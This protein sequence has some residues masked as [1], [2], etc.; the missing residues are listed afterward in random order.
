VD[1]VLPEVQRAL[2]GVDQSGGR[3]PPPIPQP[4]ASGPPSGRLACQAQY[5]KACDCQSR[6]FSLRG[7]TTCHPSQTFDW[8][9]SLAARDHEDTPSTRR[10]SQPATEVSTELLGGNGSKD[11]EIGG[12]FPFGL[13]CPVGVRSSRIPLARWPEEGLCKQ[14][15][16]E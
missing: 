11:E 5:P 1:S 9:P 6:T 15:R 16:R 8:T 14:G 7:E 12:A 4:R 2:P 3:P 13:P 10:G